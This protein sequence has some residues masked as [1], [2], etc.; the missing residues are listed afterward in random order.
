[1]KNTRRLYF[2]PIV[3][4]LLITCTS[5]F[6]KIR[7]SNDTELK[8]KT[9]MTYYDTKKFQK[10]ITLFD[11]IS[12]NYR[13]TPQDDTINF[14]LAKSYFLD[15]DPYSASH[16]FNIFRQ[17]FPRSQFAEEASYLYC[18]CMYSVTY[19]VSLD[20][21]PSMQALAAIN[22]F[23]YTY[24]ASTWKKELKPIQ[25][26]LAQRLDDKAF[27]SARLYYQIGNYK[28]ATTALKTV[29]K[30]NPDS[31]HREDILYLIMSSSYLMAKH[32]VPSKQ[33]DRYQTVI[34]EY[35]NVI[36]EYPESKYRKEVDKMQQAALEF[37]EKK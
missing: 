34:D 17:T 18:I 27:L 28:S 13:G 8:Y 33:K 10:A 12:L 4:L 30:D 22:E 2:L 37:L 23:Y 7:K 25:E 1:M 36:S 31:R 14:Y 9:A 16:Y 19:R 20:P 5:K 3:C 29:L 15:K 11:Q 26:E 32:S 35:F 21:N 6:E 24:P